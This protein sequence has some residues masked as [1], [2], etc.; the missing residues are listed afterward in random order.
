MTAGPFL[1]PNIEESRRRAHALRM[2]TVLSPS[3]RRWPVERIDDFAVRLMPKNSSRRTS[4]AFCAAVLEAHAHAGGEGVVVGAAAATSRGSA[5]SGSRRRQH[6]GEGRALARRAVD[7]EPAAMAVDHVLDDGES[8]PRATELAG[9]RGADAGEAP[10]KTR[11]GG[12]GEA[13]RPP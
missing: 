9:G 8:E 2:A 13:A 3:L 6:H 4:T 11:Q 1:S 5:R 7:V 12:G 10:G